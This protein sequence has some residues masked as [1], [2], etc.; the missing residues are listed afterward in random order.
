MLSLSLSLRKVQQCWQALSVTDLT[1]CLTWTVLFWAAAWTVS[2]KLE[3]RL[4]DHGLRS[5]H[6]S[7]GSQNWLE[8]SQSDSNSTQ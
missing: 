2:S 3:K 7:P 5:T 6:G 1:S 4:V 8:V